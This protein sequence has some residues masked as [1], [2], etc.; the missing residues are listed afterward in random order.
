MRDLFEYRQM[1]FNLVTR[2]LK[3]RYR[4]S[5]IGFFWTFLNPLLQ[6]LIYTFAFSIVMPI[7]IDNYYMHLFVALVPW[8]F[9][10]S[11][12]TGGSRAVIDQQDMVKK[13]Y[14]PRMVL[15]ISYTTSQF[16][17]MFLSFIVVLG[18]LI[19]SGIGINLRVIIYLP[20]IMIIQY[21]FTLGITLICSSISV[22]YRDLEQIFGIVS[23]GLMYASPIVYSIDSVP[24]QF[25]SIIESVPM[26]TII[27]AYRDILYYKQ[28]PNVDNLIF[29]LMVSIVVFMIGWMV[30]DKLQRRFVEEF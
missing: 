19:I 20:F 21:I 11:C 26:T 5:L 18:V 23:V 2:D 12:M 24:E 1:I 14:F 8:I 27:V 9:F 30:F 10:S 15:P 28:E 6:L 29:L 7:G 4:N 25:R 22:Y 17:N 16:V 13:I 3:G